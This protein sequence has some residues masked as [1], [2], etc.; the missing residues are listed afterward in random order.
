MMRVLPLFASVAM[1][2]FSG[3]SA[4]G[5]TLV[6]SELN[7]RVEIQRT[8]TSELLVNSFPASAIVS[9]SAVEFPNAQSLGSVPGFSLVN[10]AINAGAD[11]LAIDFDNAGI[12]TFANTFKNS[13]VFA[14]S[15]PVALQITD[16]LIDPSTTLDLTS[17][18]VTFDGNELSVNVQG[19]RFNSNSFARLN[20]STVAA[21]EP[22][23]PDVSVPDSGAVAVPEPTSVLSLGIV[24]LAGIIL[25][26]RTNRKAL[27]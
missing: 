16:V 1:V 18:R 21:S 25:K 9:E 19:L 22:S 2:A 17:D 20:L 23:E 27:Q 10:V 26:R 5:A 6:G 8:P 12:G 13:Y 15:A 11:Y 4:V 24:A 3:S 14:F 7:L